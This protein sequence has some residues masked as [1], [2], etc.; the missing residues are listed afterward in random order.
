MVYIVMGVSGSGKSTIGSLLAEKLSVPFFDADDFHP[1]QNIKKMNSGIP[2]TD[3]DR[4][5][6]LGELVKQIRTWNKAD[7]AVLACS[8]L[9]QA[10]RE[11]LEGDEPDNIRFIYLKGSKSV[12]LDRLKKRHSHYMPPSLLDS[13]FEALEEPSDA[14]TVLISATPEQ[15]VSQILMKL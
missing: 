9:K 5:P 8:A 3:A 1:D 15:I 10:Y 7:G 12:I 14:L 6:W 13:Q 11:Y 2:L 4:L